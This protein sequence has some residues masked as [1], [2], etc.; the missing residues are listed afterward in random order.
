VC[1]TLN[2][3]HYELTASDTARLGT[4]VEAL[5]RASGSAVQTAS[6]AATLFSGLTA[7]LRQ[8]VSAL[9]SGDG[10]QAVHISNVP[11]NQRDLPTT[12]RQGA[13][14]CRLPELD[15]ILKL[16]AAGLGSMYAFTHQQA[17][18]LIGDVCP[19]PDN[20]NLSNIN[21][22][23]SRP[24][25]YHTED[26]FH[27]CSP[28]Y[29]ILLCLRNPDLVP[30]TVSVPDTPVPESLWQ[31][32]Y[33]PIFT[34]MP[35]LSHG[36][37]RAMSMRS[38]VL[39]GSSDRPL[40]RINMGTIIRDNLNKTSSEALNRLAQA[41]AENSQD[42]ELAVGDCVILDNL[43]AVHARRAFEARFDGRDRWLRRA[44]VLRDLRRAPLWCNAP[45]QYELGNPHV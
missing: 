2:V 42:V 24:F 1:I 22:G 39:F 15:G 3:I 4:A 11:I 45:S 25:D 20:R 7:S 32:L 16:I 33:R 44:I 23:S 38:P 19:N 12:P 34:H 30:L 6:Q 14:E 27:P 9:R 41:F 40:M 29:L 31:A 8:A 5:G 10:P 13:Q 37:A 21:S 36:E 35:S 43:R 17:G 26:A 28:D 18:A